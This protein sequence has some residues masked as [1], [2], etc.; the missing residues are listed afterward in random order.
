MDLETAALRSWSRFFWIAVLRSSISSRHLAACRFT[1]SGSC[2][3]V[4]RRLFGSGDDEVLVHATDDPDKASLKVR[5][6]VQIDLGDGS[7]TLTL[8]DG[9]FRRR[10]SAEISG[11][12]DTS[13]GGDRLV[14]EYNSARNRRRFRAFEV[15]GDA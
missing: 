15:F 9:E 1:S 12:R 6:S 14:L 8:Q 10:A 3:G 5:D 4:W 7:D 11:G 13:P 2:K